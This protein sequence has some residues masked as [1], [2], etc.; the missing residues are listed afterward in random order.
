ML[1]GLLQLGFTVLGVI[2][3]CFGL[4]FVRRDGEQRK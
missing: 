2:A 1:D 4:A 3:S